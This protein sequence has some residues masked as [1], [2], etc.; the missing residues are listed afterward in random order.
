MIKSEVVLKSRNSKNFIAVTFVVDFP[1]I[2]LPEVL[3]HRAFSRN[4][5]SS[6]AIKFET[7]LQNVKDNPFIPY[8]FQKSHTG[9]Q[10]KE[11]HTDQSVLEELR[12]LWL[13]ARDKSVEVASKLYEK[14]VTKQLC[15]RLLEPYS[16]V[17]MIITT[18]LEGLENFFE[19]RC[20]KYDE[21]YTKSPK[22]LL[23]SKSMAEIHMQY[24][25]DSMRNSYSNA[26][27]IDADHHLPFYDDIFQCVEA[28]ARVSYNKIQ[29]TKN[30][31]FAKLAYDKHMSPFEHALQS[32]NDDKWYGNMQGWKSLRYKLE[33]ENWQPPSPVYD[34]EN[35]NNPKR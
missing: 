5:S 8:Y 3:T 35:N 24:L 27:A 29:S 19:L 10:G 33:K 6:R 23:D 14:D 26:Y 9:M 16:W 32:T 18:G 30:N 17:K 2:I 7:M 4:T 20:S 13:E 31:L 25:A 28:C 12:S 15:N 22:D 34:W 21:D 1:R 11:Y